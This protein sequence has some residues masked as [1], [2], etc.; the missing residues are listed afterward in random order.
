[1]KLNGADD[2]LGGFHFRRG[3]VLEPGSLLKTLDTS[4]IWKTA[5]EE[6]C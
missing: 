3:S 4:D 5:A 1:M 2:I 6:E